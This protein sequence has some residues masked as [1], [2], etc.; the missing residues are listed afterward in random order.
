MTDLP[1]VPPSIYRYEN[2]PCFVTYPHN[3]EERTW[4]VW[5]PEDFMPEDSVVEVYSF[6][7]NTTKPVHVA[8]RLVRKHNQ[9]TVR[10]VM[11]TFDNVVEEPK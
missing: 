8:Y 3:S 11:A 5:G 1:L 4:H 6:S 10:F 7:E 9:D 2:R